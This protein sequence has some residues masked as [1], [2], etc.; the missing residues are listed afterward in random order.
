[1]ISIIISPKF[2]KE[3]LLSIHLENKDKINF[4]NI[5][6]CFSLVYSIKS[7]EG[8]IITKQVG[9]YYELN[10]MKKNLLSNEKNII[11][12]Q[13]Q[14]PRTGTYNLSCGP[15][16]IFILDDSNNLI[17]SELKNLKFDQP[18][19]KKNYEK[20]N[21]KI[22]NPIIPEP[23]KSNLSNNFLQNSDKIF[24]SASEELQRVFNSLKST[25]NT[26][27]INFNTNIGIEI[28]FNKVEMQKDAYKIII[29]SQ[30]V[31]IYSNGYGGNF[32]ALVSILQLADYY[33]GDLPIGEIEDR[34]RFNWRGMHLDCSRQFHSIDQIKRLLIYMSLFK[35]NRF[36]WHLTDNEAWRLELESF[37][38]LAKKSSY[39]GYKEI[40]PPFYGSGYH[41]KG[42]YYSKED[43]SELIIFAK[44]LNIEIMPEI[45]LPAHSWALLQ[46]M[47]ELYDHS[48]NFESKD[49]G[50][51]K[52]NTINPALPV[53]WNFLEKIINDISNLFSYNVIHL[54]LDERPKLAWEGSPK[55]LEMMRE[56]KLSTFEEVQD[57]YMNKII[58]LMKKKNK[59]TAAWNEAALS[60]HNDIGSGGSSGNIDKSCLI[61]AWEHP[62]I[63]LAAVKKGFQIVMCP[64]QKTYF[65]MAHNNSTEERG[66]CWAA[67]IEVD[68][69]HSWKPLQDIDSNFHNFILGIQ[70]QLWSET[71]TE[72]SFLDQ[73]INPRLATLAEVAWSSDERRG[74][75]DFKSSLKNSMKLLK[76]I[77][78]ECHDF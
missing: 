47:P 35:L 57:F 56:K 40:I 28:K 11:N 33:L 17:Q 49:V 18:I 62:D 3:N 20:I 48:S 39:R 26:L 31:Q 67:T 71:L 36:H 78:W 73:M 27:G 7:L 77:G 29:N 24:F 51:Y 8:A 69:I 60:P 64:G 12:I 6:L 37:P 25:S 50:N 52:N 38:N 75:K 53:T 21:I 5:K 14:T 4:K 59:I 23:L 15:E 61:F 58:N 55:I 42:G 76:K 45:D 72:K 9:R 70:G 54:G 32:Y 74:W 2:N 16:G 44:N 46:I 34:P 43:V 68:E 30:N 13:L 19:T 10:L 65:D 22:I 66:I 63:A 1:M 41:K